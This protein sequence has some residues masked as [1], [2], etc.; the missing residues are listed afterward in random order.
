MDNVI[1]FTDIYRSKINALE[2]NI[3]SLRIQRNRYIE[4]GGH[5]RAY[6]IHC[7]TVK[8]NSLSNKIFNMKAVL[9]RMLERELTKHVNY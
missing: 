1:K 8:I 7:L 2:W 5:Q 4:R 3:D 6:N 9:Q